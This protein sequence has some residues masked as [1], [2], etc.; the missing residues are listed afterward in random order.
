MPRSLLAALLAATLLTGCTSPK[1]KT[2]NEFRAA[3]ERGDLDA[4]RALLADDP[5]I[6]YASREGDGSAWTLTGGRWKGWDDHFNSTSEIGDWHAESDRVWAVVFEMN[7]YF[8]LCEAGP[9][10]WTLTYF[11]DD[12][13]LISGMMVSSAPE[14]VEGDRGRRAEFDQWLKTTHPKEYEDLRHG[15]NIDPTGDRPQRTRELLHAWRK[16]VGLPVEP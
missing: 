12:Q 14:G 5:R 3:R 1:I 4:A 10:P 9:S 16:E 2:A 15:G 11:F 8:R 6:W 7:E 13:G